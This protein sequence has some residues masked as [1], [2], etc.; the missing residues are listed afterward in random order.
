MVKTARAQAEN[1]V[2]QSNTNLM[3]DYLNKIICG[4]SYSL[5]K[6]IPD[7]SIDLIYTDIPYDMEGNGG[8]GCFGVKNREFYRQVSEM[9]HG[10]D[11][12]I[13]KDFCRVL[14][15]LNVYIWCNQRQILS[16]M[17]FFVEDRG[18]RYELLTWHKTNPMPACSGKYLSD[19]E[20]CLF[21]HRGGAK[22]RRLVRNEKQVL[23]K[24]N[25]HYG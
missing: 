8:G 6:E 24:P 12:S 22:D 7:K 13:L 15:S 14:K 17:K 10:I 5:I 19:T 1:T 20:Y 23:Y 2:V 25:K 21:F 3:T 4:D 18:C 9:T 11:Y 16:L